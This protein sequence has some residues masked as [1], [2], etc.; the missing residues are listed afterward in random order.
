MVER[1]ETGG[2]SRA[3]RNDLTVVFSRG[4]RTTTVEEAAEAL[5]ISR[6]D[7]ARRLAGW[8]SNGWLR[9]VRRGL[10]L[11]VPVDAPDP[12]NWSEDPWYLADLVWHPCYITGWSAAHHW[13]LTDQVFRSTVVATTGR[14]RRVEEELAGNTYLVHHVPDSWL[15]WGLRTEWRHGRR[16]LV[17]DPARTVAELLNAPA[18]GGGIRHVTEILDAYLVE[19]DAHDLIEP[20]D[21]LGNGAAFKRLG[22]L[23]EHLGGGHDPNTEAIAERLTAGISLLDPSQST[24]GPRSAKWGLL[25]NVDVTA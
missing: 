7:A 18:L 17:A 23:L 10:Y 5:G 2:L 6:S 4:Q 14:V 15:E 24:G 8:A 19:A 1:G 25:V 13:S 20:L 21:K 16:V 3:G 22:Y 9:R 11:S 12:S